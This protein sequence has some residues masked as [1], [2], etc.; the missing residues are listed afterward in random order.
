MEF[1]LLSA[2]EVE[3]Y[4]RA[5]LEMMLEADGDF[6]PPLSQR[7]VPNDKSEGA[8]DTKNGI[9]RYF[10]SMKKEQI[11]V[12]LE[13]E[14]L[15][16]F[17]T[18]VRDLSCHCIAKDTF[19]NLYIGTLIVRRAARGRGITKRMYT[20]LFDTLCPACNLFTRTWSTNVAHL[21]ILQKFGFGEIAR[22]ANDRGEGIDTVYLGKV[23]NQ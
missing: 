17:V 12:A 5:F 9:L 20:Y 10:E 13:G 16:G 14:E 15:L 18:F 4:R 3:E 7:F 21:G 11:L 6:V 22:L 1:K 23:R 2:A 8:A 19:P